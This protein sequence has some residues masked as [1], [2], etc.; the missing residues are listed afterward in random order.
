MS[1]AAVS[2]S[3][4]S[5]AAVQLRIQ[6][7]KRHGGIDQIKQPKEPAAKIPA[8]KTLEIIGSALV[9]RCCDAASAR[10]VANTPRK[11][12]LEHPGPAGRRTGCGVLLSNMCWPSA[13][14]TVATKVRVSCAHQMSE[15]LLSVPCPVAILLSTTMR[16]RHCEQSCSSATA[17]PGPNKK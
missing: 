11:K 6:P 12:A 2:P 1:A 3:D 17:L 16:R 13:R 8:K 15:H 9:A 14:P 10:A 4:S 5:G 7:D